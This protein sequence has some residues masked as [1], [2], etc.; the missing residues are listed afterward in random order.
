MQ[1]GA[2]RK[3][4]IM[5]II[6]ITNRAT[7]IARRWIS[8]GSRRWR[9]LGF[10][11]ASKRP[12]LRSYKAGNPATSSKRRARRAKQETDPWQRRR[13]V[14]EEKMIDL[15]VAAASRKEFAENIGGWE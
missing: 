11:S 6:I 15:R 4:R 9:D 12:W 5:W 13:G 1:P 10:C 7:S 3:R 8:P 14:R 2:R